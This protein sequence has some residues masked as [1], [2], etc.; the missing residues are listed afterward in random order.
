[1]T[2]KLSQSAE[3]LIE[4]LQTPHSSGD[5]R[6]GVNI[7]PFTVKPCTNDTEVRQWS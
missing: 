5:N 6:G 3:L 2:D 1:M 4:T 7:I